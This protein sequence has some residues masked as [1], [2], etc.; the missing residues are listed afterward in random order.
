MQAGQQRNYVPMV[1][2]WVALVQTREMQK[3]QLSLRGYLEF[4][5]RR[6]RLP[7]TEHRLLIPE[8]G[9]AKKSPQVA[10]KEPGGWSH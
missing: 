9:Q 3:L 8:V 1:S 10:G 7:P 6:R 5:I 4:W 2:D